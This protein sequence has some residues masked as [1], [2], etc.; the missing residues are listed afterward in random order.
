MKYITQRLQVMRTASAK[1]SHVSGT[2]KCKRKHEHSCNEILVILSS[3][4]IT[5]VP[6]RTGT[7][8]EES[9]NYDDYRSVYVAM[10]LQHR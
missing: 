8:F 2:N 5:S 1:A 7:P 9:L 6:T 3:P 10:L 4:N